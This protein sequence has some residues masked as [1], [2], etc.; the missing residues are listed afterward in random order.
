MGYLI[1]RTST[2]PELSAG[3]DSD[4]WKKCGTIRVACFRPEGSGHRPETRLKLQYDNAGLYGLFSVRDR[5]V[6]CVAER[7]QDM[8]CGDSCIE[9]FVQPAIGTG[10][11]NFEF[12]ASGVLL[13]HHVMDRRRRPGSDDVR[14]LSDQEAEGIRIFHT[15]PNRVEPEI[16]EATDYELGFF[17]PF[18]LFEK[19]HH[20]PA[21]V[22]GTVWRGNAFK[23]GDNTSHPHWASWRPVRRVN[24]HEPDCFDILEFE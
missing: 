8:V 16:A 4:A 12:N 18:T 22:S 23:C 14:P 21:P 1:C 11:V 6:R 3:F 19:T 17:I 15:L 13:A 20:A 10:Y 5:F 9:L 7:F 2:P 24:F